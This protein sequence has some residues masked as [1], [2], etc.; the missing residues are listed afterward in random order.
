ME[1]LTSLKTFITEFSEALWGWGPGGFPLLVILLLGTGLLLTI[2]TGAVQ[3]RK[4][5][6]GMKLVLGG[7]FKKDDSKEPGD[8]SPFQALMTSLSA[9]VGNGNIAGV[10][11]A[12]AL[13][14]PGAVFWMWLTGLF[15]MATKYSEAV[16]GVK[17]RVTAEDGS[18]AG[19]PM[20]YC[21]K[22]VGGKFGKFLGVFFAVAG[23]IACLI[24]TGNMF[25]A[26]SIAVS[27]TALLKDYQLVAA[28]NEIWVQGGVGI[29]LAILVG[30]V[31]LG[32]VGRI[33]NVA[34]KLVPTMIGL[35]FLAAIIIIGMHITAV[36]SALWLIVESAFTPKGVL[37]GAVGI[38]IMQAIRFG[39]AR[40]ILSNESGLGSAP[41][42]HAA[43][44]TE[45][46]VKQGQIAMMG[47]FIDTL[48][49][50][51]LTA[52]VITVTGAYQEGP[53]FRD[54]DTALRG[55]DMTMHAFETAIPRS[56]IMVMIGSFL[57]GF[58]TLLGWS[59][60]GEKCT[61]YLFGSKVKTGYR[62]LFI[63][64]LFIGS[65]PTAEGIS[66]VV[67]VGDIGNAL[68]AVPN[69][70]A[71]VMLAREVGRITMEKINGNDLVD[72]IGK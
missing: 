46:P 32:G 55:I 53:L 15:G 19:G 63:L 66:A 7:A 65:L 31:I 69:L 47:T 6:T 12:I 17:Y 70:I 35:Y 40:G 28:G 23:V 57:F 62:L 48:V 10:A 43:A 20:Y 34:E 64:F 33:G 38:G 3:F 50:C 61:E 36:P 51:T 60:Y 21:E 42:A 13:G 11:T 24:G 52:L 45:S 59:Y 39:V 1:F 41:I 16:L 71:L 49:V 5:G 8:I 9:T 37:G 72:Q 22:G 4:F 14:G 29:V 2:I 30:S 68:M 67:A 18:T 27:F 44:K 58:S 26:N 54:P 56:S 25:Q